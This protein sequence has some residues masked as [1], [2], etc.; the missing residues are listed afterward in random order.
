MTAEQVLNVFKQEGANLTKSDKKPP[1]YFTIN[2]VQPLIYQ[3]TALNNQYLL[4]YDFDSLA[5]AEECSKQFRNNKLQFQ[6]LDLVSPSYFKVKNIVI[7]LAMENAHKY[8]YYGKVGEIIFQKLHDT[9]K[10]VFEGESDH[11][12]GNI[13]VAYYEYFLEGEKLYYDHYFFSETVFTYI[14]DNAKSVDSFD[15]KCSNGTS[16]SSGH[17]LVLDQ[18]GI[19]SAGFSGGNGSRPRENYTYTTDIHWNGK[20][21]TFKLKAITH[22]DL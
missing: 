21:E 2:K 5:N 19:S 3:S 6:N 13:I 10:L 1:S 8:F 16:G 17:G 11:W 12:R 15:Y 4:I 18:D 22:E 7:A 14:G 9:K 20:T